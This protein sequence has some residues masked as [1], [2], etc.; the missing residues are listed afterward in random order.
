MG[1][2][3][4]DSRRTSCRWFV[5]GA[6][7]QRKLE[8]YRESGPDDAGGP[9]EDPLGC[10]RWEQGHTESSARCGDCKHMLRSG[11][12]QR[13]ARRPLAAGHARDLG[14]AARQSG[15]AC[16][17][18]IPRYPACARFELAPAST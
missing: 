3:A 5:D 13:C 15:E 12:G 9:C 6:C 14:A 7:R 2:K 8:D 4:K 11:A 1:K 17:A 16:E 10:E 18:V